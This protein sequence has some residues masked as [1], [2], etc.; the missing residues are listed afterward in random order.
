MGVGK[1]S[2]RRPASL[3]MCGVGILESGLKQVGIAIAHV[4][5]ENDDDVGFVGSE[6]GA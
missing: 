4:V 1:P 6:G 2:F 3:S 5:G